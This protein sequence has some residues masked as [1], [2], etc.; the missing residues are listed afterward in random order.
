VAVFIKKVEAEAR[1]H[2]RFENTQ[3]NSR[4][5]RLHQR[6]AVRTVRLPGQMIVMSGTVLVR[7]SFIAML[8]MLVFV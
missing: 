3:F 6:P 2:I 7:M 1:R 8:V 5:L 4:Q